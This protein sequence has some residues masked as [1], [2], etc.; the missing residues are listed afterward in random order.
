MIQMINLED[1][2]NSFI[3]QF[4]E[5][6][7]A[8]QNLIL[9]HQIKEKELIEKTFSKKENKNVYFNSKKRL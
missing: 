5:N 1:I 3:A 4:Y 2:M 7:N 6:K 9:S 8:P